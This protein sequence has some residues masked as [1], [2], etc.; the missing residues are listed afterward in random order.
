MKKI[1]AKYVLLIVVTFAASIFIYEYIMANKPIDTETDLLYAQ[2]QSEKQYLSNT[3]YTIDNPNV[4]L[5]PYGNSPLSALIVFQTK[6]L[7]TSTVTIKGK[8]GAEDL[9]ASLSLAN[10]ITSR[11]CSNFIAVFYPLMAFAEGVG[12]CSDHLRHAFN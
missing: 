8:D 11:M 7:T 12:C 2:T 4:I 9:R 3:N 5:N 6:D 10:H 1:I